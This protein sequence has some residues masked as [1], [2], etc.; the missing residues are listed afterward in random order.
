MGTSAHKVVQNHQFF[1]ASGGT[2]TCK[3]ASPPANK[4]HFSRRRQYPPEKGTT[5]LLRTSPRPHQGN[6]IIVLLLYEDAAPLARETDRATERGGTERP[7]DSRAGVCFTTVHLFF[8]SSPDS[9]SPVERMPGSGI[10]LLPPLSLGRPTC[11]A[12]SAHPRSQLNDILSAQTFFS[13][14][15]ARY[16]PLSSSS[17]SRSPPMLL[18]SFLLP[19]T[20]R[21]LQ[22]FPFFFLSSPP[23]T[24]SIHPPPVV[25]VT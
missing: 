20:P 17:K 9:Q 16:P 5:I 22:S 15:H 25:V 21:L 4:Q 18:Q 12:W 10:P 11:T 2:D 23:S 13:P 6:N 3:P 1:S 7:S 19:C 8:L 14:S 24:A